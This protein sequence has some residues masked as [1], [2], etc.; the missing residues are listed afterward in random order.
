MASSSSLLG[1]LLSGDIPVRQANA[2]VLVGR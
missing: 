2:P 1:A